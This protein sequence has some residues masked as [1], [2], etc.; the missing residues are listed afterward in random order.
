MG[1][2]GDA[3]RYPA[4]GIAL[5]VLLTIYFVTPFILTISGMHN[6]AWLWKVNAGATLVTIAVPPWGWKK[7]HP[8]SDQPHMRQG[9]GQGG[10]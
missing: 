6:W 9:R 2:K 8:Y 3:G 10:I 5:N 4:K 7:P 1:Y